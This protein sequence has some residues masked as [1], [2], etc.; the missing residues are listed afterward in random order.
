MLPIQ[1]SFTLDQQSEMICE[2]LEVAG[3]VQ[4]ADLR[5]TNLKFVAAGDV[6][7]ANDCTWTAAG[8]DAVIQRYLTVLPYATIRCVDVTMRVTGNVQLQKNSSWIAEAGVF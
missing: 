6:Q 4:L 2:N 3:D 8:M 7:L 1:K 5:C